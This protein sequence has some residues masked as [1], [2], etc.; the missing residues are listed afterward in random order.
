MDTG[1]SVLIAKPELPALRKLADALE[2]FHRIPE[3]EAIQLA[4]RAWGFAGENLTEER[5]GLLAGKCKEAGIETLILDSAAVA[6]LPVEKNFVKAAVKPDGLDYTLE[7]KEQG[8]AP[9]ESAALVAAAP[10]K[11]ETITVQTVKEGP[12]GAQRMASLA[13]MSVTGLP[14]GFGKKKET[15][16]ETRSFELYFYLELFFPVPPHRLKMRNDIFDYSYL[17]GR[18]EYSSQ[19]NF[20]IFLE[21]LRMAAS[22]ADF[23]MGAGEILNKKPLNLLTY[24]SLDF[25]EK[26][27]RWLLTIKR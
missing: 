4:R 3:D 16:K 12:S 20:R 26:E 10:I 25:L 17:E 13:I 19:L 7:T 24:D 15:R 21:D 1:Y 5:A 2:E 6:S 8:F 11:E 27:A 14:I 9:W 23:N 22:K 18:K